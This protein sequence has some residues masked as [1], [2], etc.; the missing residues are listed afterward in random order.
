MAVA[1]LKAYGWLIAHIGLVYKKRQQVQK[2]R[3][4]SDKKVLD[5]MYPG[6]IVFE[7]FLLGKKR[8]SDLIFYDKFI[9]KINQS[10][11]I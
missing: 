9:A 4:I 5:L 1:I 7:F 2:F 8:F 3:K 10:N 6:S 11:L